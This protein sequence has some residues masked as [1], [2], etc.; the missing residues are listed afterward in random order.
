MNVDLRK[1]VSVTTDGAPAMT[2]KVKGFSSPD[3]HARGPQLTN[4]LT[5]N[6]LQVVNAV[7]DMKKSTNLAQFHLRHQSQEQLKKIGDYSG[8]QLSSTS[9]LK[10][11]CRKSRRATGDTKAG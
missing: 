11:M 6:L 10:Q 3:Q 1:L 8:F 2:G 4:G 9:S 7:E 5:T